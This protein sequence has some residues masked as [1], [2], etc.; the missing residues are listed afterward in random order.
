[1]APGGAPS[2]SDPRWRAL[3]AQQKAKR[4]PCW[5]CGQPID[6]SKDYPHPDSFTADHI[7]PWARYPELRLDPG[8]VV[9][10]HARCNWSKNDNEHHTA[11]LGG[12]SEVF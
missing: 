2:R 11:G 5:L 8:N 9:S 10:S 4:L 6:Y 3:R 7:K 12:L 1:M